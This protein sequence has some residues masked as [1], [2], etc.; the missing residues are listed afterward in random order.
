MG[1]WSPPAR[2]NLTAKPKKSLV[3]DD[4]PIIRTLASAALSRLGFEVT[5]AADG[6]KALDHAHSVAFDLVVL[7]VQMPGLDGFEVCQALRALPAYRL[8]PILMAT[9]LDDNASIERAFDAGASDFVAKPLN[10]ALLDHRVRFLMKSATALRELEEKR[11][12]LDEALQL[13]HMAHWSYEPG[14]GMLVATDAGYRS[15]GFASGNVS[16]AELFERIHP[17]DRDLVSGSFQRLLDGEASASYEHRFVLPD[18]EV[19]YVHAVLRAF[20]GAGGALERIVG[21]AQDVTER[22]TLD[23]AMRLWS[24]V[25]ETT[26]EGML[27]ADRRLRPLQVN[28][29]FTLITGHSLEAVQ[30]EPEL[31]FPQDLLAFIGPDLSARGTW[32]GEYQAVRRNGERYHQWLN[33]GQLRDARGEI[34][35]HVA[36]FSDITALK[37]SQSRLNYLA[38]HDPLTGLPNRAALTRHLEDTIQDDALHGR[39]TG[40]LY[41]DLDR[42]KNVNDSLG[43]PFGDRLLREIVKRVGAE[44]PEGQMLARVGGDEF[45]VVLAALDDEA[46]AER[47]ARA[48]LAC[49]QE[50]FRLQ[51]YEFVIGASIGVCTHPRHGSTVD[52]LVKNADTAMYRAKEQGR[53][54]YQVYTEKMSADILER[55]SLEADLRLALTRGE[56]ELYYQ[57]KV[58]LSDGAIVGAEALIRWHHPQRGEIPPD[59]FVP[60]AEDSGLIADIG[61]WV[62]E[63]A[64]RAAARWRRAP[65]GLKHVAV[66]VSG[67][68]IWRSDFVDHVRR[69]IGRNGIA[70]DT[71]QIEITETLVMSDATRD[72]TMRRLDA[73]RVLGVTMAIDDF[74]TG[75]SSLSYLKR[76]PVSILKIDKSFV[77]DIASDV[78]DEAIVRAIIALADS[79]QLEL[80]AEGVETEA[81]MRWLREAGCHLGQGFLFARPVPAATF[82]AMLLEH[83]GRASPSPAETR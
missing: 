17:E 82:E 15:Y 56:L 79:L 35:H 62:I 77:R 1:V 6:R 67:P 30:A 3:P 18:G 8:T 34:T 57:P 63:E 4:D 73:L 22:H 80:V 58:N 52:E 48:I 21:S 53:N 38:S 61:Q 46:E 14:A 60:V 23:E 65:Y 39:H 47:I 83:S 19:R 74:G 66:N 31:A 20:R 10:L 49:L 36:M 72:D 28:S 43:H 7:D 54:R 81:Q 16:F 51:H 41:V 55:M 33:V 78:N 37:R 11:T 40:V 26:S 32:Q 45:M 12:Q 25:I 27:I 70:P 2:P 42:F 68:Q 13:A 75:H 59:R 29:A 64:A 50:A 5:S 69:T 71:L 76:L 44:I 24:R 9:G